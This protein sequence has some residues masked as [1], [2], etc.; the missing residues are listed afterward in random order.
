MINPIL[1]DLIDALG[2]ALTAAAPEIV[3]DAVA[4]LEALIAKF[5]V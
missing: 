3:A 2:N 4:E 1:S 5:K